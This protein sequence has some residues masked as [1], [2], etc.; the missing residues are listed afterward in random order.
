MAERI[1]FFNHKG[2]V[3][4]TLAAYHLGWVLTTLGHK[5]LLVDG[6]SQVNLTAVA[7]GSE[8]FDGFYDD[9]KTKNSNIKAGVTPVFEGQPR[10]IAAFD[11]PTALGNDNLFVLPG[12]LDLQAYE[13][14]LSLAQETGGTLSVLRNL[15]GALNGL[16]GIIEAHH[17]I[18]FT[19]I[20]LNPGLG[21]INQNLFLAADSFIVPTNPDPFSIMALHTLSDRVLKWSQWLR[22]S[23]DIYKDTQYPLSEKP[24][25]FLGTITS[26]F[27]KHSS[28]AARKFDE[29]IQQID[30]TVKDVLFKKL[31]GEGM[32]LAMKKYEEAFALCP[33]MGPG[34]PTSALSLAR[35]PDFQSLAQISSNNEVPVVAL[36]ETMLREGGLGGSSLIAAQKNVQ[37]FSMIFD[38]VAR[39]VKLLLNVE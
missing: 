26:R 25:V 4:K 37:E 11:C 23:Y 24:A 17:N 29:R 10:S 9:D 30:Q 34:M 7:L 14:Q 19:L 2:G 16:I 12:H 15:P 20:D 36:N 8:A 38:C 3:G 31:E 18:D 28:K 33:D 6:D 5:V 27:N 32:T 35:I 13:G 22:T 21:A 39:K 1:A